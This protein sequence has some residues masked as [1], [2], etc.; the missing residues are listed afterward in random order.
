MPVGVRKSYAFPSGVI[1]FLRLRR[2]SGGVAATIFGVARKS[3][4]FPHIERR[5]RKNDIEGRKSKENV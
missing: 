2:E 5:S 4:A 1:K 3:I